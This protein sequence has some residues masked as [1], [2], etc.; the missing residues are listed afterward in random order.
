MKRAKTADLSGLDRLMKFEGEIAD[1]TNDLARFLQATGER[2]QIQALLE[3]A[4]LLFQA[5]RAMLDSVDSMSVGKFDVAM[6]QEKDAVRF[7]IESR[8]R[9]IVILQKSDNPAGVNQA[10]NDF[11]RQQQTKLRTK[12]KANKDEE[13]KAKD[14]IDRLAQLAGQQSVVAAQLDTMGT[15]GNGEPQETP[16][17]PS[18]EEN[19]A[20]PK[21]ADPKQDPEAG[22]GSN[23]PS[24]AAGE[25]PDSEMKPSFGPYVA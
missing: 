11:F 10:I 22:P 15:S 13:E 16:T 17:E 2:F 21:P 1:L 19:T 7:L 12:P 20:T 6:L 5:E 23:G 8:D 14:L 3:N 4:D 18:K 25:N 9:L 24:D